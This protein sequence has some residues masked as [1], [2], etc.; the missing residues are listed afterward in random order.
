MP[1]DNTIG[2]ILDATPDAMFIVN[3]KG[4]ILFANNET[5]KLFGYSKTELINQPIEILV[6]DHLKNIHAAHREKYQ[7]HPR[8]R[9]MGKGMQ[10]SAKRK[11]GSIIPVEISLS[12]FKINE[13]D[14]TI[15]AVRD[16]TLHVQQTKILS[17]Y[18]KHDTLTHLLNYAS[19]QNEAERLF[20]ESVRHHD[21]LGV[22]YIDIDNFKAINDTFGHQVGDCVLKDIAQTIKQTLRQG[23]I[24][25]RVG[26]DE[27]IILLPRLTK[28]GD[29]EQVAKKLVS[30][31]NKPFLI[32][33]LSITASISIG[34]S[35]YPADGN[36]LT[37]IIGCADTA[38][39]TSKKMGKGQYSC[40]RGSS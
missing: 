40:Y 29:A 5:V 3:K 25:G 27:F 9:P 7:T 32:D 30:C 14:F 4:V 34:V 6:P 20:K 21:F 28:A 38:L 2:I 12:P 23:D 11:D 1:L 8:R 22:L 36:N 37:T 33:Q 26:G 15:A 16:S 17:Y 13:E 39:Y 10:L 19:F 35:H 24:I 31:V 18:A